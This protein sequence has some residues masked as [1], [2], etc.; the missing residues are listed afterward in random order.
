MGTDDD[1]D[2][3]NALFADALQAVE[4]V[5]ESTD[6]VSKRSHGPED[7]IEFEIEIVEEHSQERGSEEVSIDLDD[8]M[9][10]DGD[11]AALEMRLMEKNEECHLLEE[12][13]KKAMR[14][15]RKKKK[16]NESLSHR[17]DLLQKEI[18]RLRVVSKQSARQLEIV[19]SRS[20]LH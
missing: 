6:N 20:I 14:S 19:E 2:P 10:A 12:K 5:S 7:E 4:K 8:A 13:L 1:N 11:A 15:L 17:S 18:G 9:G 3:L 16:E